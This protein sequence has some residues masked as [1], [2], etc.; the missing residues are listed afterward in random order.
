MIIYALVFLE[1]P[2]KEELQTT[3]LSLSGQASFIIKTR[4]L[5]QL[6]HADIP[7]K[8]CYFCFEGL[9]A[10]YKFALT[11]TP[12][13]DPHPWEAKRK[14]SSILLPSPAPLFIILQPTKNGSVQNLCVK[15]KRQINTNSVSLEYFTNFFH[16]PCINYK[17]TLYLLLPLSC[18]EVACYPSCLF[19]TNKLVWPRQIEL[20]CW[21][22]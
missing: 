21:G 6:L 7:R 3:Q 4:L 20:G 8:Y 9:L 5:Q 22:I 18:T 10:C 11:F 13:E 1:R 19:E 15:T 2:Y 14:H 12:C 17:R 16:A